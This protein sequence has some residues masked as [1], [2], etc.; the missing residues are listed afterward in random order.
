VARCDRELWR[1]GAVMVTGDSATREDEGATSM[2]LAAVGCAATVAGTPTPPTR[3]NASK[4]IARRD[5][6]TDPIRD[7]STLPLLQV[8]RNFLFESEARRAGT[9]Y[10]GPNTSMATRPAFTAQGQ[11]A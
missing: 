10:F 11:P 9:R 5:I 7:I 8:L 4:N 6:A 3:S 1:I 2:A